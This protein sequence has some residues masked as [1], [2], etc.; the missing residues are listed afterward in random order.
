MVLPAPP[1]TVAPHS[2]EVRVAE[3]RA[4]C[5]DAIPDAWRLSPSVW[6]RLET[7][8]A[9]HKTNLIE[10]NIPRL[11]G[12]LTDKEI[13]I[14]ESYDVSSLL[15]ELAV[16]NLTALEV[17]VAFSK[18]A[19]IAQ[20]LTECLTETF[21]DQ[22]QER[23]R[24]LDALR[25]KGQLAGPLHGLPISIKDSFQV[26]GTEATLG[27]VGYL[28]KTSEVNSCLVDMLLRL[29][30]VLYVKTN[31][32]QTLM[33]ADSHNNV[34]GRVLNPW[35]TML[36][37]GGSSGGE[38]ALVAFRGSP[39]GVGTDIAGSIRIP[40][41]CCGTYGFKPTANRIPYG[42][43]QDLSNPGLGF[44][45]PCAGPIANDIDALCTF[46]KAVIDLQPRSIDPTAI[47]VPW[48][49][50]PGL[51]RKLKIGVLPEDALFPL[52]PPVR[53]AVADAVALLHAQGHDLVHLSQ[54][55]C[56][57]GDSFEVAWGLFSFDST[58]S[59][60]VQDGA[61]PLVP[62]VI[63][64]IEEFERVAWKFVPNLDNLGEMERLAILRNK[65]MDIM[66]DWHKL[67][68]RHS[69]DV[70]IGPGAQNTA[71]AHDDY[72]LAPYTCLLNLI[73]SPA[74]II[75]FGKA[76]TTGSS[77]TVH[78]KPGQS[79]SPYDPELLN[80]APLAIQVFTSPMLDEECLS[81]A[82]MIDQ[83]LHSYNVG[84]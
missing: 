37:A 59:Q 5:Q 1:A 14:T 67:W 28:G 15:A 2:W 58:A 60:I 8:L 18:R 54:D 83:C 43:Q 35:N 81:I 38:G 11:S 12:I 71:V 23:A 24:Q 56:H 65:R 64:T 39:L 70:V 76:S 3:K 74:C 22:A 66:N 4:R 26:V 19:A 27:L 80:G 41:L 77:E 7:P 68:T 44:I 21:F 13:D 40:S 36:T 20:Q 63:G 78:K 42:Q 75:P 34:F 72:N 48:R 45:S 79:V 47:D 82:K 51:E 9:R 73:D 6:Q 29:G 32:P 33:T 50:L 16:G 46:V 10:L 17:T 55:E 53:K 52:H 30:A 49:L 84:F 31:V 25:V 62:S 69:L 61:E 57:I